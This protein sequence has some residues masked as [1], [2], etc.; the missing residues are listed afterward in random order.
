MTT[1]ADDICYTVP[2]ELEKTIESAGCKEAFE[3]SHDG[4]RDKPDLHP[5]LDEGWSWV[6]LIGSFGAQVL[7]DG[8][9]YSFGVYFDQLIEFCDCSRV[10]I[11][12]LGS[13]ILGV[14]WGTGE[15]LQY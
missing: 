13:L 10:A 7:A 5:V 2:T 1:Q 8:I 9:A 12:S 6:V 11:G 15:N 4:N 14:M 3:R